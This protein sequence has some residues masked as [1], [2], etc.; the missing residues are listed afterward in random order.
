MAFLCQVPLVLR[1]GDFARCRAEG[2][3]DEE[4]H[5]DKTPASFFTFT[6]FRLSMTS[7]QPHMD[8]LLVARPHHL[9]AWAFSGCYR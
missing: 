1:P 5:H 6:A 8:R 3:S 2:H 4:F 9:R 7:P